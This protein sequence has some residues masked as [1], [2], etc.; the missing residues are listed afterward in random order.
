MKIHLSPG[1]LVSENR[2]TAHWW[3]AL[4]A[5]LLLNLTCIVA[6]Y[7]QNK[8]WDKTIGGKSEDQLTVVRQT[9]D[10]GYILG[11]WSK[12]GINGNKTT[13]KK[14]GSDY[15]IVKLKADGT[16]AWDKTFGGN[17]DDLLTSLQQTNDGGYILGG[18]SFSGKSGDKSEANR[19]NKNN[20]E[21]LTGDYWIVK[22]NANGNK[23]WDKTIGGDSRD[24]LQLIRQTSDGGYIVG[25]TSLSN[26]SGDK[27]ENTIGTKDTDTGDYWVVKL[28]ADGTKAWDNTIGG[29][30]GDKLSSVQ[31]TNDGGYL[32]GGSS[33][34][35]ISGDKTEDNKEAANFNSSDYWIVKLTSNGKKAWDKTLGGENNDELRSLQQTNDG[36]YI[37]GGSSNSDKSGDK[38][39]ARKGGI[40]SGGDPTRDYWVVKINGAG[41]KVW[42]K[43]LGGGNDDYLRAIQQTKDGG[44]ILG[45]YSDSDISGDKSEKFKRSETFYDP[46]DFWV[47][48]LNATGSKVWDK[49]LGGNAG[50]YLSSLQQTIDGNYILGGSSNSSKSNDKTQAKLGECTST[51]CTSDYW[52]VKIDNRGTNLNQNITF[53]P[54]TYKTF[55]D[56]SF[57]ISAT[58]SSG[59]PVTFSIVSGPATIKGNIVTLT[60]V[61][62]VTVK[63]RQAG[64]DTYKP[65]EATQTFLVMEPSLV[66]KGWEKTFG[67]KYEDRLTAMVATSDGGYL[68]GGTSNSGK[69]GDR[70]HAGQG[71]SKDYWIIKTDH[72]GNKLWDRSYGGSYQDKLAAI[73]ATSDGGYLLGGTS[74]S[75]ISGDKTQ[76]NR[77][78][79]DFWVVKID[80]DGN[81]QWDK[82]FGGANEDIFTALIATPDGGYLLGGTS[83][84]GISGDKS[85]AVRGG[86]DYW[87]VK[88]DETGKKLWDKTLGGVGVDNLAA[89]AVG[90]NG[91]YLLGGSSV[92]GYS[93]DKTQAKRALTDYWVVRIKPTGTKVWDKAYSGIKGTY[94]D[95]WCTTNCNVTTYGESVLSGLITTPDGGFLLGGTSTTEPGAEKS[96]DNLSDKYANLRKYWV[97]KIND[98]GNKEWDKTY[99]GGLTTSTLQFVDST[100]TIYGGSANLR[101]LISTPD[102]GFLLAGDSDFGK[103][104][105]KSEDVRKMDYELV[106]Y[107]AVKIDA[108]GVKK[109]DKTLGGFNYDFLSA[110]AVSSSGNYILGGSSESG[111]GG[112]KSE[113]PR[114]TTNI[115]FEFSPTDYWVVEIKDETSSNNSAWN[116]RYGGS[117]YDVLTSVIKTADGGYLSGG[118]SPSGISGDKT[119][120]S[121]GKNDFWIVKTNANG[122]KLWDK[123]YGGSG[124]DYLNRVIQTQDG[125]YLLAGSSLSGTSGDK[126]QATR[127]DRDYWIVKISNTGAKQ[128]DKRYGGTGYDELKKVIQLSTGEYILAGYSNSPAGGNKSQASQGGLDYWIVKVNSTGSQLW[129]KTY[130]GTLNETLTGIVQ[131]SNGGFLLG[132]SSLSDKGGNK[133]EVSRG[134]SDFW[135]V[136][137]DK[138]GNQVWDKTYGGSGQDEAYSLGRSGKSDYFISGQSDSPVG[139]DKTR[140]SQGFKDFWFLKINSTGGKIWDKRFGGNFDDEVRASI[141]TQDGGYLLAGMSASRKSGNKTQDSQGSSDYWIVKTDADGMYQWDK[142]FGGSTVEELR[143][144]IQTDDGGYLLA[145]KSLS[146]ASGDRKQP[147]QGEYDYWLVKVAPETTPIIAAREAQPVTDPVKETRLN[148]LKAYPNP[149]GE[150]VTISFTLPQTQ[151]ANVK[152]YDNQGWEITTLFQGEAKANQKYEVKWQAGNKPAGLY[153][154][155]LQTPTTRQQQKLLLNK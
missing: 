7:A 134:G 8:I 52:V 112:D 35:D 65:A 78:D 111:I 95:P 135:L 44:Y 126:T 79:A 143:A 122:K 128:W 55:G 87:V 137:V 30:R 5:I 46:N 115:N 116:M 47:V 58:A 68:M 86:I 89:L 9:K 13:A 117:G 101:S 109:W 41:S 84:S 32:V 94:T 50:D 104:A 107:W 24:E 23:L 103:G 148:L 49:T 25:G 61:G 136:R 127:G 1:S 120:A 132:G 38:T 12:S 39:Q 96:E 71:N 48:K 45:G 146:G 27:S 82:T 113:A 22:L 76:A 99:A 17:K 59:L 60:G 54:I 70:S 16:K 108:Q 92:S 133:S 125:G 37:L 100:Y 2:V 34:S 121:R 43:T 138:N 110:A 147:S 90:T 20:I 153:F 129:D 124:D 80:A 19:D 31:Q 57:T 67:G 74:E 144:V 10:G 53:A 33:E 83:E 150:K 91:D 93:G 40:N 66:R 62:K 142:R 149:F 98:Q 88:L 28:K 114:D 152:V 97:V 64:N 26:K 72:L 154:L 11:G 119:Q 130:G 81:K 141:Q 105:D 131:A 102:G 3:R 123:R 6:T 118:Y 63:A 73:I 145:G 155:Q 85:E 56:A 51:V 151:P 75:D 4:G 21:F 106:D 42:D 77:G 140:D 29:S 139:A 14:G 69:S 36:G 18:Y 15:W